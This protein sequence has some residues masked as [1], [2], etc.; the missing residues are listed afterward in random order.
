MGT[1]FVDRAF[2]T[3]KSSSVGLRFLAIQFAD[4][5]R[6]AI[7]SHEYHKRVLPCRPFV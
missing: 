6:L 4:F 2:T 5:T 1:T 3:F 7:V